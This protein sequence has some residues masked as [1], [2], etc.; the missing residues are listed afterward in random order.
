MLAKKSMNLEKGRT[1]RKIELWCGRN[2][3]SFVKNNKKEAMFSTGTS[4]F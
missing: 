2:I 3:S 4:L 1:T